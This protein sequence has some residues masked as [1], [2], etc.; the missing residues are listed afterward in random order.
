M[1]NIEH[2]Y[3]NYFGKLLIRLSCSAE[4]LR[5][6]GKCWIGFCHGDYWCLEG[7]FVLLSQKL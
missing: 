7:H 5:G 3:G 1:L 6:A 4:T 2:V